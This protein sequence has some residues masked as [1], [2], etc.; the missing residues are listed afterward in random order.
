MIN[1]YITELKSCTSRA[2]KK[3]K[4]VNTTEYDI[5]SGVCYMVFYSYFVSE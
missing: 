4:T 2:N 3:W 5:H 1:V